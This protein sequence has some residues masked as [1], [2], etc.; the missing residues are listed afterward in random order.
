MFTVN[1][2][3]DLYGK[4]H[5]VQLPFA[6]RPS[7]REVVESAQAYFDV[8]SQSLR[9]AGYPDVVFQVESLQ[10]LRGS[11]WV[12][13][14][15]HDGVTPGQQMWCFQPEN[16][17]HSDASG[18]VPE[19]VHTVLYWRP[20]AWPARVAATGPAPT[21]GA[22]VLAVF[23]YLDTRITGRVSRQDV[24]A[25]LT[26]LAA[27]PF[28]A[29]D[30]LL[31]AAGVPA[32]RADLNFAEFSALAETHQQL[33][34]ALYFRARC[35]QPP[36]PPPPALRQITNTARLAPFPERCSY[37]R[38]KSGSLGRTRDPPQAFNPDRFA[39]SPADGKRAGLNWG[40]LAVNVTRPAVDRRDGFADGGR[41]EEG[42][43]GR[44]QA[45]RD[46][47]LAAARELRELGCG[48]A[49]D[50]QAKPARVSPV[51]PPLPLP[52]A[53]PEANSGR[54]PA[55]SSSSAGTAAMQPTPVLRAARPDN[56]LESYAHS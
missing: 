35:Q 11:Q 27:P 55:L 25:S 16:I 10:A 4:K 37:S 51:P 30:T 29:V 14:S 44:L 39:G 21:F 8:L 15:V 40:D 26:R 1:V 19:A 22:K 38:S 12:V 47:A 13:A 53:P 52:P 9:P 42:L 23:A 5:N 49:A 6:A 7:V 32:G 54:D 17:W 46:Q 28:V 33:V 24:H 43:I 41:G 2:G 18:I 56:F 34:D 36:A 50:Q 31:H 48:E 3:S 20:L 45:A